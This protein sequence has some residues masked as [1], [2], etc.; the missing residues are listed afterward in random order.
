MSSTDTSGEQIRVQRNS[1]AGRFEILVD[2][3]MAGHTEYRD[4]NGIRTFPHT[5]VSSEF[6]GRGLAGKVV[7]EALRVTKEEGLR[8]RPTCEYVQGYIEKHPD[9]AEL[10]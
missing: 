4:D 6:G 7:G 1:A 9:S 3:V 10:A 8:V 5:E 2:D